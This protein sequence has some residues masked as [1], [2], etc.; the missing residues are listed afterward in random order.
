[1]ATHRS[2]GRLCLAAL[3]LALALCLALYPLRAAGLGTRALLGL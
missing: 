1:M 3:A 2:I